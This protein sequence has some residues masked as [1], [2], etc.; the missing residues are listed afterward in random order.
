MSSK[1]ENQNVSKLELQWGE[2]ILG[3]S[4]SSVS[5]ELHIGKKKALET[6]EHIKAL[7]KEKADFKVGG[8]FVLPSKKPKDLANFIN[9]ALSGEKEGAAKML[10]GL[11]GSGLFVHEVIEL[12]D[13][14][15]IFEENSRLRFL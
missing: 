12:E 4:K 9:E 15:V 8:V 13:R 2:D 7:I 14:C 3:N 1:K 6:K 10:A 5:A 11:A